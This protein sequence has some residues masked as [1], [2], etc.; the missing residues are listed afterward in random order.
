[1]ADAGSKH[2]RRWAQIVYQSKKRKLINS[3]ANSPDENA[4][5][6]SRLALDAEP[7]NLKSEKHKPK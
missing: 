5:E 7:E 1:M 4:G 6:K 3:A 2:E